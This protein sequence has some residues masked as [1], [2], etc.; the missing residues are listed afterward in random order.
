[1]K[2]ESKLNF[3]NLI[4]YNN[5]ISNEKKNLILFFI[6]LSFVSC[7]NNDSTFTYNEGLPAQDFIDKKIKKSPVIIDGYNYVLYEYGSR[8]ERNYSFELKH[9][10]ECKKMLRNF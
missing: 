5:G 2:R 6:V 8:H 3:I 7:T 1:M 4:K 9:S 10:I